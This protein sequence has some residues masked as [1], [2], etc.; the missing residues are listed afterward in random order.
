M[1]SLADLPE[2]I[3]FFSY[4]REDDQGSRGGLSDLRDAIQVELSAQLGRSQTDF[5]IWQDKAAISLGMLW[6]NE[7]QQGIRQ[8]VFFIPI[9]TPRALRSH[10]CGL[11]FQSFLAREA[12]LGRADLVFP[13]LYIPVPALEDEKLWR[14]DPVL[15]V[16]GTRQYLDWRELRH[17][18]PNSTEVRQRLERF[19]RGI[20]N[21]LHKPWI[22]PDERKRREAEESRQREAEEARRRAAEVEAEWLAREAREREQ[23]EAARRAEEAERTRLVE[24]EARERAAEERRRLKAA[25]EKQAEEERAFKM[26]KAGNSIAAIEAF[27]G[28]HAESAFAVE[29]NKV[30]AALQAREVSY[31]RAMASDNPAVLMAFWDDYKKGEDVGQVRAR[32]RLLAPEQSSQPSKL[33]MIGA[34][35]AAAIL[36][37]VVAIWFATRPVATNPPVVALATPPVG[38]PPAPAIAPAPSAPP[39]AAVAA[40]NSAVAVTETKPATVAPPPAAP[41][42]PD[43]AAIAWS[44]LRDTNDA[45]ALQRFTSQ[46]PDSPLRKEAETRIAALAAEQAAWNLVKDTNDP[47]QLRRFVRQ[48]PKS[49]DRADAEQRIA[50]LAAAPPAPPAG[51]APDPHDLARLLQFELMRVGCFAGKVTG[52]F[53]DD[54][55]VAWHKFVKLTSRNMPDDVSQDAINAVRGV[56][57]RVCPLVC[58]HGQHADGSEC[59]A[60]E[61]PPKHTVKRE[62][63][64]RPRPPVPAAAAPAANVYCQGRSSGVAV[65]NSSNYCGN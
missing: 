38:L 24:Q 13:I 56:N 18:D 26:A 41:P 37:G 2:L 14:D 20:T 10:H 48:F 23:A 11:E 22:S 42:A 57:K 64:A 60:N 50:S 34:G 4:S 65:S 12:E 3:G 40:T 30:K 52:E 44:F 31:K 25:A 27:L 1:P 63:P 58:P 55:K 54:T 59:V 19:C 32:L 5:R 17:H 39:S 62:A 15:S 46:F 8:S 7:I 49:L 29:A 9:I 28:A 61:P 35:A 16:V 36:I 47:E 45:A 33:A 51:T 53:D 6:E 43:P 21:A